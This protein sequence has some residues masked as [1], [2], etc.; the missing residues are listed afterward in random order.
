MLIQKLVLAVEAKYITAM[1]NRTTGQFI[2][3]LF[4]LIQYFI[5]TYGKIYPKKTFDLEQNTKSI[6]YEPQTPIDTVFKRVKDL[7][8]YGELDGSPY[9]HIQT[10]N[11][12]CMII[13]RRGNFRA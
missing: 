13:N 2:G 11:N 10:I 8:E 12:A 5:V 9:T 3:T 1:K 4:M 7:L 6:Q